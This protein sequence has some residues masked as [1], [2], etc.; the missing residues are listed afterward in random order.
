MKISKRHSGASLLTAVFLITAL[1]LLG[2]LMTRLMVLSS[3]ETIQEWYAAQSLYAAE[4]GVDWAA[5]QIATGT[6]TCTPNSDTHPVTANTTFTV[7]VS[8]QEI[9]GRQL[10][11]ITSTGIT[12][13]PF[14]QVQ[15][16]L[17]VQ[18][19]P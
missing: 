8:C 7:T 12:A 16:R 11:E 19:M 2:A 17:V 15:R 1:A 9:G 4:S 6:Y 18:F 13:A 5:F 3:T 10:Y 14:G